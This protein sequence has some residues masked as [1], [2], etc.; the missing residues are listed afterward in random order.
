MSPFYSSR[1]KGLCPKQYWSLV[2]GCLSES[3]YLSTTQASLCECYLPSFPI[4]HQKEM[5]LVLHDPFLPFLGKPACFLFPHPNTCESIFKCP[6]GISHRLSVSH[7]D[8]YKVWNL[9]SSSFFLFQI[10]TM[11]FMEVSDDSPIPLW[12]FRNL[13]DSALL[14]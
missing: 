12:L 5:T 10:E 3:L 11:W 2:M 14:F 7:P 8:P 4:P 13:S 1:N 6:S 9:L